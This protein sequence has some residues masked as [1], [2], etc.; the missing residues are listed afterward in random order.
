MHTPGTRSGA[1]PWENTNVVPRGRPCRPR[2]WRRS[3]GRSTPSSFT[4]PAFATIWPNMSYDSARTRAGDGNVGK[5]L[6]VAEVEDALHERRV[7][8]D[9]AP[10]ASS[11]DVAAVGDNRV[12]Q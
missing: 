8:R 10:D 2:R 6:T 11:L 4:S 1:G 9:K 7:A 12:R 3:R 5:L